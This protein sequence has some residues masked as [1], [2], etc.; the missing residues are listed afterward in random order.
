MYLVIRGMVIDFCSPH[1]WACAGRALC[2]LCLVHQGACE[3][4]TARGFVYLFIHAWYAVFCHA[5]TPPHTP[6]VPDTQH[7][8]SLLNIILIIR[9]MGLTGCVSVKSAIGDPNVYTHE[10][11]RLSFKK[12]PPASSNTVSHTCF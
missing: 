7:T 8:L 2:T 9:L 10:L 4:C 12:R 6:Y 3:L 5:C 1:A 11:S